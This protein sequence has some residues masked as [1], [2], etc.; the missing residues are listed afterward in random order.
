MCMCAVFTLP[1]GF[2]LVLQ[3]KDYL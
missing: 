2:E 1:F 3:C